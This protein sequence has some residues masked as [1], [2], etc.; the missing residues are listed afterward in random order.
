MEQTVIKIEDARKNRK[1]YVYSMQGN[2]RQA[3]LAYIA[4]I[5]DGEG[6]IRIHKSKPYKKNKQKN[7]SY[8]AGIGVGMVEKRIPS[9]LQEVFGGGLQEECVPGR[10]SIW[11]WQVSGRLSVYKILEELAPYLI[12]KQEHAYAVMEFCEEWHTPFSRQQGLSSLELQRR[13]DAYQ[14]L[15]K[16]NAV[17]AAATTKQESTREGEVIV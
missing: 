10:R 7:C 5:I 1:N 16:L 2:P 15:R 6:T 3:T 9:L 12:L 8:A 17:G 4:G 14:K 13:E 11:R